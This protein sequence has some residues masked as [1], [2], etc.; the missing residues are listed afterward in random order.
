MGLCGSYWPL[1][2][3]TLSGT[4]SFCAASKL[5]ERQDLKCLVQCLFSEAKQHAR[6]AYNNIIKTP[7]QCILE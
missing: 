1:F 5:R 6:C 3:I 2:V 7:L 4:M